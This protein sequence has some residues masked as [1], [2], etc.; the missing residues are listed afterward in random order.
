[1]AS[2][3]VCLAH[4]NSPSFP[5]SSSSLPG[6]RP[7]FHFSGAA[8]LACL[9]PSL[10]SFP[11]FPLPLSLGPSY[12]SKRPSM[13]PS[14]TAPGW[15]LRTPRL[16]SPRAPGERKGDVVFS[17][18]AGCC[19]RVQNTKATPTALQL[20]RSR[21]VFFVRRFVYRLAA[22][23]E[24][25]GGKAGRRTARQPCGSAPRSDGSLTE[26]EERHSRI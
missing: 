12:P 26:L 16:P 13:Q 1:M 2:V 8:S 17:P 18:R 4:S 6:R 21:W 20:S 11:N 3:H 10:F 22:C 15:S 19:L 9:A 14:N 7:F 25:S 23:P 24:S 5:P